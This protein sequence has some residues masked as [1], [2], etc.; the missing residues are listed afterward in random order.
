[1]KKDYSKSI[2]LRCVVCGSDSNF[3]H[4]E[5]NSYIKCTK[6]NR[7]YLGGYDELVEL[8]QSMI[9]EEL[10]ATKAE[11]TA[12]LNKDIHDMFKKAFKGNKYI[13]IK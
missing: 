1:M 5:D 2:Q 4:N 11:I 7:E 3:E 10:E 8:N 9:V 13:K 12:D 6:C